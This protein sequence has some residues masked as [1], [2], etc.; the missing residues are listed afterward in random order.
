MRATSFHRCLSFYLHNHHHTRQKYDRMLW[1]RKT[2]QK[3][4]LLALCPPDPR[5][6]VA[7]LII[8]TSE[9]GQPHQDPEQILQEKYF[10]IYILER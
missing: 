2:D 6:S 7:S 1:G 10:H 5:T 9:M 8:L 3:P 4:S